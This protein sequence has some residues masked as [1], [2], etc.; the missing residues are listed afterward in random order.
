MGG[1]RFRS[2]E[3]ARFSRFKLEWHVRQ[4]DDLL[5][6]QAIYRKDLYEAD[7]IERMLENYL[8]VLSAMVAGIDQRIDD[9]LPP[10]SL[11]QS[12]NSQKL[13]DGNSAGQPASD[14]DL[15]E[16][17]LAKVWAEVLGISEVGIH[18]NFFARGGDSIL[19]VLMVA[20]CRQRGVH[21]TP[22]QIFQHKTIASLA[23]VAVR[24]TQVSATSIEL[25]EADGVN[26]TP[27]Q[28]WFFEQPVRTSS[29]FNQAVVLAGR[30]GL[31]A[32]ALVKAVGAVQSHHNS[33]RL[34]FSRDGDEW[35]QFVAD[36]DSMSDCVCLD[37]SHVPIERRADEVRLVADEFQSSINVENGT[38]IRTAWF[39]FG[40][41]E[42]GQ[43][44]V[45]IHHL[46]VD[47]VSWRLL[48]EDLERAYTLAEQ[49]ETIVLTPIVT[50]YLQWAA[51]LNER[52]KSPAVQSEIDYWLKVMRSPC[53][54]PC[55]FDNGLNTENSAR[56][57]SIT[58]DPERTATLLQGRADASEVWIQQALLA[59]LSQVLGEWTG[60]NEVRINVEGHGRQDI[61][62][63]VDV[64][65]TIG[66]FTSIYPLSLPASLSQL[67][68]TLTTVREQL[69][70]VHDQ[71]INYGL[72]RFF[73]PEAHWR[74]KLRGRES[75]AVCFNYLGQFDHL[76]SGNGV[77]R[78]LETLSLRNGEDP[79]AYVLQLDASII[80]GQL[81]IDW[82]YSENLHRPQT[83]Q[84]LADS[85]KHYL[86][87]L[88]ELVDAEEDPALQFAL[89]ALD[90]RQ[91][92][93]VLAEL[94]TE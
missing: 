25:S 44:L 79:R 6:I 18:E 7:L 67:S 16:R 32:A 63:G 64:S 38:L 65:R 60:R 33:L 91:L 37:L 10:I 85:F 35:R 59:S 56:K 11:D 58:F 36:A 2:L 94:E 23:S 39:D 62:M 68:E 86:W 3:E 30:K 71:G 4:Q 29:R 9:L 76:W 28:Q 26:L 89:V 22:R 55:D 49:G 54:I 77:F 87:E 46:A 27:I 41:D 12:L 21:I 43:L 15:I 50:P 20:K 13:S 72:L 17:E 93:Q 82:E 24:E 1:V 57:V 78:P 14:R 92:D 75:A 40:P 45:I 70:Q 53:A 84:R 51:A 52:A 80:S 73:S 47:G 66:W 5:K 74:E 42:S 8:G 81:R 31:N 69:K 88:A 83:I 34:R 90:Q 48:L 19:S 61:S